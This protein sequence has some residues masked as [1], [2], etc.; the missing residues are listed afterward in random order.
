LFH[1][2]FFNSDC[3][4]FFTQKEIKILPSTIT[5]YRA[6]VVRLS[7]TSH[8]SQTRKQTEKRVKKAYHLMFTTHLHYFDIP[9]Q[10][11]NQKFY[12]CLIRLKSPTSSLGI[13]PFKLLL[14]N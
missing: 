14:I 2:F 5:C 12:I 9:N 6:L 13:S 1:K 4:F 11:I 7:S 3:D 10:L 8:S